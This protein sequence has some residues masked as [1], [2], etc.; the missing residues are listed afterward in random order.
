M[1]A[2]GTN[3]YYE[4]QLELSTKGVDQT[5]GGDPG[6]FPAPPGCSATFGTV[7]QYVA[8]ASPTTTLPAAPIF[9]NTLVWYTASR[10]APGC[11]AP[12][13]GTWTPTGAVQ[14]AN[15]D[16]GNAVR[17]W[18]RVV[19]AG[20]PAAWATN[21]F[22]SGDKAWLVEHEGVAVLDAYVGG[23]YLYSGNPPHAFW[24]GQPEIAV[25][26][27]A[28]K[29]A[30]L[31]SL[32]SKS[33]DT[34]SGPHWTPATGMTELIDTG[35]PG[36]KVG[37]NYQLIS[38]TSGSYTIG[39]ADGDNFFANDSMVGVAFTCSG[40]DNPPGQGQ[41]VYNEIPTPPPGGGNRV[42][43][44]KYAYADGSLSVL[45]DQTA[46]TVTETN[47]ATG[48]FTLAFDP[49]SYELVQVTYQG[50]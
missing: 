33:E 40:S 27:T 47:P 22:S 26:P 2:D 15:S 32:A 45:V 23:G 9:G 21:I 19:V 6:V 7:V 43:Y 10:G 48:A 28:G 25:T 11:L 36:P 4:V 1:L 38:A 20:D 35:P 14:S 50:R 18:F 24:P 3:Q 8:A 41:W 34:G 5:G 17:I 12:T 46:Q 42:F 13:T 39:S 49:R 31:V 37:I 30:L 29:T 44:T 16:G